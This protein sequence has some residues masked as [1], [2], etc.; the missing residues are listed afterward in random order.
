LKFPVDFLVGTCYDGLMSDEPLIGLPPTIGTA[1]FV[2]STGKTILVVD[3]DP[4]VL[5]YLTMVLAN[6]YT[7][8]N[9]I[10]GKAGL[11][12][13]A[14]YSDTIDLLLADFQMPVMSG[15]DL[16]VKLQAVRPN[17]E[18]LLMSGYDEGI[19]ILNEGWHFLKK[20]FVPSQLK[21]LIKNLLS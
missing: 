3:D 6:Q 13:A 9:A 7:V 4:L 5:R 21:A 19:L 12:Q 16:A 2:G 8:L 17:I 1:K 20:P 14:G 18:V 15:D 11:E 10:N